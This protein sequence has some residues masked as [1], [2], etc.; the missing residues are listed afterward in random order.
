MLS[1]VSTIVRLALMWAGYVL[2]EKVVEVV[3][4]GPLSEPGAS[5]DA[6]EAPDEPKATEPCADGSRYLLS[7][8]YRGLLGGVCVGCCLGKDASLAAAPLA[9]DPC[10]SQQCTQMTKNDAE[11]PFSPICVHSCVPT[12]AR[13]TL[14]S[15][16]SVHKCPKTAP[17]G[18][19]RR[20]VYTP[21]FPWP[22]A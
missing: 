13:V 16:N 11:R 15:R 10:E 21:A 9:R 3:R 7:N 14:A 20:F 8:L 6:P 22:P 17:R 2:R 5:L 1:N 4:H 18:H 19:F 12:D